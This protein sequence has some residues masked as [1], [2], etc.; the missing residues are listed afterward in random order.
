LGSVLPTVISAR[1]DARATA[2]PRPST[3]STLGLELFQ[4]T[5]P[6]GRT[7]SVSAASMGPI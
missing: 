7:Q 6:R 3:E 2:N 1:P 5:A 4:L